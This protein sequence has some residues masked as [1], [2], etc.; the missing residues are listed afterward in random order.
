MNFSKS[1]FNIV[2]AEV[3]TVE[4][5]KSAVFWDVALCDSAK[6]HQHSFKVWT[7]TELHSVTSQDIVPVI[8]CNTLLT[9]MLRSLM[10]S[11]P[12]RF[13]H[14]NVI[15]S[16][17]FPMSPMLYPLPLFKDISHCINCKDYMMSEMIMHRE[18]ER[19]HLRT[20]LKSWH[21]PVNSHQMLPE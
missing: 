10:Y 20:E 18:L 11:L 4:I 16:S 3:P 1:H 9:S 5:K 12:F 21:G 6:I 15:H 14:Q 19:K 7:S 2:E 8:S 13:S 17:C